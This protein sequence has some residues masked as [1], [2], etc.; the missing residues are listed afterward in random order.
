MPLPGLTQGIFCNKKGGNVGQTRK[1]TW[2]ILGFKWTSMG[3]TMV[4]SGPSNYGKS[5][6]Q[7]IYDLNIVHS[8]LFTCFPAILT[9]ACGKSKIVD[10]FIDQQINPPGYWIIH[11]ESTSSIFICWQLQF[12]LLLLRAWILI[13]VHDLGATMK[14]PATYTI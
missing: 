5:P 10:T 12:F 13:M 6:G 8:D 2:E 3:K 11:K 14:P 1:N 7:I 4:F 9:I